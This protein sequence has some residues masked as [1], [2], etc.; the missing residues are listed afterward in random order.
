MSVKVAGFQ[1]SDLFQQMKEGIDGMGADQRKETAKKVTFSCYFPIIGPLITPLSA[2]Q[3]NGIFQF[4][5]SAGGKTQS[6]ALDLKS[7]KGTVTVG[8]AA[9]PDI[10]IIVTD[11]NFM[12]L[13]SGQLNG[14]SFVLACLIFPLGEPT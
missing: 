8:P 5:I 10:T 11:E 7:E 12:K 9:K 3:V 4:D 1:V 6:W 13:A 14:S 2:D